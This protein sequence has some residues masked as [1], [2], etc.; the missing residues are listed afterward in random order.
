MVVNCV[1]SL[2]TTLAIYKTFSNSFLILYMLFSLNILMF[3]QAEELNI[4]DIS[5]AV[6]DMQ[7]NSFFQLNPGYCLKCGT[8]RDLESSSVAANNCIRRYDTI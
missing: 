4:D 6:N 5:K 7:I 8:Y 3:V 2:F 1:S